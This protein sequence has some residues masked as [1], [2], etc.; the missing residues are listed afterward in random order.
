MTVFTAEGP[1]AP[2]AALSRDEEMMRATVRR[3]A[4]RKIAPLTREMDERQKLDP[5]IL[6]ELFSLGLM[7]VEIPAEWGGAGA[8][9]FNSILA[10]EEISRV[11]PAV[12]VVVDVQNTLTANALM[13]WGSPQQKEKYLP[14][15]A[16]D[17]VCAYALSEASSGSDAFALQSRAQAEGDTF[18]LNGRKLWISNAAEAGVFLVFAN[19]QPEAGHRGITAFLIE[20]DTPGFSV[21]KKED[22]LGIRAS[23]T[24][25]LALNDC[26]VPKSNM[27][28]ALGQGYK[29]AME[30]LNDGRIGIAA[31]MLGLAEG[32]W[33]LALKYSKERKQFGKPIAEFQAVSFALAEMAT[34]IEA[35]RMLVYNAAR[36]KMAG[37][38]FVKEAAMAKYFASNVA[39]ETASRS[40]EIFGGYGFVKDSPIEKFYRDAKIGKIYE[41][42][43]NMQLA[44]IGKAILRDGE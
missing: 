2:L 38:T 44:T 20:R 31:Q 40:L 7:G 24:C 43:S 9:F 16:S 29:V 14:R 13:R 25:E 34:E 32:A 5:G 3:F 18:V 23:S 30:A 42:T 21:G 15:L 4:Q 10:V 6:R 37:L 17:T 27:L 39:E 11:D 8:S 22:K 33:S 26:R 36:M 19:A 35:A 28:G 1:A 12:A 41:G